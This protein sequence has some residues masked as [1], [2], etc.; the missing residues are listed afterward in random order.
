MS[1]PSADT[2]N[3]IAA[4]EGWPDRVEDIERLIGAT[5]EQILRMTD[6]QLCQLFDEHGALVVSVLGMRFPPDGLALWLNLL[7]SCVLNAAMRACLTDL[8]QDIEAYDALPQSERDA[9][10]VCA[11][12]GID[13][14]AFRRL[15]PDTRAAITAAIRSGAGCRAAWCGAVG[16]EP[17]V[18]MM[19]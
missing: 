16:A 4:R 12:G 6:A 5:G 1:A 8:S 3:A 17:P 10:F 15:P 11:V 13:F 14:A 19:H 2:W 18:L 9:H 7:P